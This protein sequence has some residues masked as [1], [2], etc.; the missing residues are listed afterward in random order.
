MARMQ[1]AFVLASQLTPETDVNMSF[2]PTVLTVTNT[3]MPPATGQA[4]EIGRNRATVH[5][6]QGSMGTHV[7]LNTVQRKPIAMH[8]EYH[9]ATN[10]TAPVLVTLT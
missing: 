10:Q 8:T 5:V 1:D 3:G 4:L 9:Q 6:I 2:A 7:N